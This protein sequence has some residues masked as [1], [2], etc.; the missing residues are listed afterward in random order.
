MLIFSSIGLAS[1]PFI[2]S[3]IFG[4]LGYA[5]TLYFF[6]VINFLTMCMVNYALPNVL[7][8]KDEDEE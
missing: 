5:N 8:K 3:A 4:F 6:A 7:N 2:G 1:G